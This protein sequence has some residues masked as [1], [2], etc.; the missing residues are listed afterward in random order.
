MQQRK[1]SEQERIAWLRLI[2]SENVGTATFESLMRFYEK[3]SDALAAIPDLAK[4]GG[5]RAIKV[6]SE[7]AAVEEIEAIEKIGAH[8]LCSCEADYPALL[9]EIKN[10]PPV[11]TVL[12]QRSVL[13]APAV[14]FVGARN[15]SL[16]GKNLTRKLAL[17]CVDN[18]VS[19][20]SGM[21]L[22][23]DGAAHEGALCSTN[24]AAGTVA[25]LGCG[26]DVIYPAEHKNL[27]AEIKERGV[28]ISEYPLKT[29]PA[30]SN[31]PR[32]N[33]LIS[34]L[35]LATLVVEA[36]ENSGSLITAE[37]A[38]EQ[39][40]IVMAVPGSP[41]DDR[42]VVPNALIKAGAV[43]IQNSQDILN[44]ISQKTSQ[45][46]ALHDKTKEVAL[47]R[48][49]A[50]DQ[51]SEARDVVLSALSA[52]P[53]AE[54]ELSRQLSLP[55]SVVSVI[56]LELELAGRIERHALGR[57]SLLYKAEDIKTLDPKKIEFM[58]D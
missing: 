39:G 11:L 45:D 37:F 33:R 35:S 17:D 25:V 4:K 53:I 47:Y 26:V 13:K 9:K 32:R 28:I 34:G 12:G 52:N 55:S 50:E 51:I 44:A 31:F 15:A 2:R 20:V 29:R 49:P 58:E 54:D 19:V 30:A 56:L 48:L 10:P 40:R 24:S 8:L 38:K 57:V 1:L 18:S 43:L 22:G 21:A 14:A 3:P 36:K 5:K 6:C 16:N 42:S 41:I 23:I 7:Q 46:F 27:Y